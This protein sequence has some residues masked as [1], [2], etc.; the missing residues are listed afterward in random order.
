DYP[1]DCL[2]EEL[3]RAA[4]GPAAVLCGSRV[5]M[6]YAMAVLGSELMDDYFGSR[7]ETLG[8]LVL[9]TKRRMVAD[10]EA[11]PA[12]TGNTSRALLDALA[13]AISPDP[14]LLDEERREHLLL[15]NLLGD[16][17]LRM[18]RPKPVQI[19]L[20]THVYAGERVPVVFE[21]D[22]SGE[23]VVELVCR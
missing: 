16:P 19:E 13:K 17:L 18:P 5:T 3:L 10:A 22:V 9:A 7:S 15:F 20:P 8:E 21:S 1:D 12:Q 2:A 14:E 11:A 6:P 4:G 23:C